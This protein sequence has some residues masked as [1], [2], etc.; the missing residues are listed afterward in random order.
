MTWLV[1]GGCGFVGSN[2]AARLLETGRRVC[3]L[4]DLSRAGAQANL[5]WL[6]A[7]PGAAVRLRFEKVDVADAAAVDSLVAELGPELRCVAHLAGQVAMTVSLADPRRDFLTNAC[8]TFNLLEAVRAHAPGAA[9]LYASTNKVYGELEWIT[10]EERETRYV[11]PAYPDGLPED[12]PLDFSSPYGCSKGAADQYVRDYARVY[13]LETVVFRHSSI[14]GGRQFST[15]DQGWVGW[16][17]RKALEQ[18]RARL[19]GVPAQAFTISGNGKQVRD[20]LHVRDVVDLY[21]AAE[22]RIEQLAGQVFNVGGGV[23]NSL[24]L[25]EL[26]GRLERTLAVDL[27]YEAREWRTADQ[28]VFIADTG[29]IRAALDWSPRVGLD[30]GLAGMLAWAAEMEGA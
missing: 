4:D 11:L 2:L 26:F 12:I 23:A 29:S 8:G 3:V 16:F 19:G 5:A 22:E 18:K 24:S 25:L 21:L 15:Y 13:G 9:F 28:K 6:R 20:L 10:V 30:E 7:R 1:T 27:V 17:C 14:Y